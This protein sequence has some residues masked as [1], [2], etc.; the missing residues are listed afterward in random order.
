MWLAPVA[1]FAALSG[2][3]VAF[4]PSY[5]IES[6]RIEVTYQSARPAILSIRASYWL[7]NTGTRSLDALDLQ[8]PAAQ[9]FDPQNVQIT[10]A[11]NPISTSG[12]ENANDPFHLAFGAGFGRESADNLTVSYELKAG[13]AQ[14]ALTPGG[15]P[16]IF[17]PSYGWYP[18]L[19][20]P[21]GFFTDGGAPPK[22]WDLVVHVPEGYQVSASGRN[23]SQHRGNG[24]QEIL[25]EQKQELYLPFVVAGPYIAQR[26]H[27]SSGEVIFWSVAPVPPSRAQSLAERIASDERFLE[28]QFGRPKQSAPVRIIECPPGESTLP[29]RPWISFTGCLPV[30]GSAVVPA[31][32]LEGPNSPGTN[33]G[34]PE[35]V[36]VHT[37]DMQLAASRFYFLARANPNGSPFPMGGAG[38]YATWA[39][40]ISRDPGV[41]ESSIKQLLAQLASF[42]S[43]TDRPLAAIS[44]DD[45]IEI[46]ERAHVKSDLFF[47]GL[48]DRCGATHVRSALAR[49]VRVAGGGT[50]GVPELRSAMETECGADLAGFFREWLDRPGIPADFLTRYGSDSAE[51]ARENHPYE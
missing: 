19:Q 48:E 15:S 5:L 12:S 36:A 13:G 33:A 34:M 17:L 27:S 23:R 24:M 41:R 38:D 40:D 44:R 21:P 11:G 42:A 14:A 32:L 47:I 29:P 49:L 50:W 51:A 26:T 6:Q 7:K 18:V 25:F 16:A 45:A 1:C 2:C 8:L 9:T 30:P 43:V 20:P 39:L 37:I 28:T 10:W 22:S 35:N 31:G 4:G 46:R 3:N